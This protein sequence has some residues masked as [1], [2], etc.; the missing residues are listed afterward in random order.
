MLPLFG[1]HFNGLGELERPLSNPN[2]SSLFSEQDAVD[3]VEVD[4]VNKSRGEATLVFERD[5]FI[6]L[7]L[8]FV[9]ASSSLLPS[10]H[11]SSP[12]IHCSS[13]C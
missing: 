5:F 2:L 7:S 1:L 9:E 6:R 11:N 10:V 12:D 3:K 8:C 4:F 13:S